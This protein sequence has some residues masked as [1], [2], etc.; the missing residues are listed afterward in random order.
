M[1]HDMTM[2]EI[3]AVLLAI[4]DGIMYADDIEAAHIE[5]DKLLIAALRRCGE[6]RYRG[7]VEMVIKAWESVPK[8]Y[9]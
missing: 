7:Y 6:S 5:A 1:E 3:K 9:S 4:A 2:A 8:W